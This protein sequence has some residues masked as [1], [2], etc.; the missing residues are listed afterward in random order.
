MRLIPVTIRSFM[1]FLQTKRTSLQLDTSEE[2]FQ[3]QQI[4]ATLALGAWIRGTFCYQSVFMWLLL[5][6]LPLCNEN[7]RGWLQRQLICDN[8]LLIASSNC[9]FLKKIKINKSNQPQALEINRTIII[10]SRPDCI[11]ASFSLHTEKDQGSLLLAGKTNIYW[12]E[13][14]PFDL[15]YIPCPTLE[16][17]HNYW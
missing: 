5:V 10:R 12:T 2:H 6:K 8:I 14:Q 16:N 15:Q 17:H 1:S 7:P 3:L 9:F 11:N 13:R 4:L